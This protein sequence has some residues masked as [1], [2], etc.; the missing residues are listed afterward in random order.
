MTTSATRCRDKIN[1]L[2][3][4]HRPF[5]ILRG[6]ARLCTTARSMARSAGFSMVYGVQRLATRRT[7]IRPKRTGRCRSLRR[8]AGCATK[9]SKSTPTATLPRNTCG[10]TRLSAAIPART[11]TPPIAPALGSAGDGGAFLRLPSVSEKC[12]HAEWPA[13]AMVVAQHAQRA[14][15]ASLQETFGP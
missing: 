6:T 14:C 10:R 13:R 2:L 11:L 5:S 7:G 3:T 9:R 8:R 12:S 1:L 4:V 15:P